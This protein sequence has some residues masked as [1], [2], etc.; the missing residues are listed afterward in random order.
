MVCDGF[1]VS[2]RITA[3]KNQSI[4]FS[5]G[6]RRLDLSHGVYGSAGGC[7]IQEPTLGLRWWKECRPWHEFIFLNDTPTALR[8][9]P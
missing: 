5:F 6:L 8:L 4:C 1:K 7:K 2:H 3:L 9:A